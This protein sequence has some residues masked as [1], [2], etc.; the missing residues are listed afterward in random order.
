MT[1]WFEFARDIIKTTAGGNL[2]Y[3]LY[4]P[5]LIY[6]LVKGGKKIRYGIVYPSLLTIFLIFNPLLMKMS[7][8]RGDY[9]NRYHRFLW[10]LVI[11]FTV[12]LAI[13]HLVF[14]LKNKYIRI[15]A[16]VVMLSLL[17]I[18]GKPVYK[19]SEG[20]AFIKA[21]NSWFV[22]QE[23]ISLSVA[24][25]CEGIEKP[26]V[27]YDP[28]L[29]T[30]MR[31][32]DPNIRSELTRAI[33]ESLEHGWKLPEEIE[34]DSDKRTVS[35]VCFMYDT[36]IPKDEF[37]ASLSNLGINYVTAKKGTDLNGYMEETGLM[38]IAETNN[39]IVYKA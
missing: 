11:F 17:V 12:A 21:E 27:V 36:S 6:L 25:H 9:G 22:P 10:L 4:L 18:M 19:S 26:L 28:Y 20:R 5:A 15:A 1:S 7:N 14:G 39:Y 2:A 8:V 31:T 23:I 33:Q 16:A 13:V 24:Y 38:P 3:W 35:R 34:K 29:L 32:Y 30:A 37:L